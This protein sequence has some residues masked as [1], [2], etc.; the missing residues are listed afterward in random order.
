MADERDMMA[1]RNS[2]ATKENRS[3]ENASLTDACDEPDRQ[4]TMGPGTEPQRRAPA[5]DSQVGVCSA[6]E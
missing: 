6:D 3:G 1:A 4:G 2:A 5:G